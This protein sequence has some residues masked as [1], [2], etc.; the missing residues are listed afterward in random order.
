MIRNQW[1]AILDAKEIKKGKLFGV[2]RLGEKLVLWRSESGEVNCIFDK[3]CHRGAS[4]SKGKLSHDEVNCPFHGF[5]Y[6]FVYDKE[7]NIITEQQSIKIDDKSQFC[8][9]HQPQGFL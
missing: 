4:L 9:N 6:N 1:Y 8:K 5:S 2:T 3:C 7:C